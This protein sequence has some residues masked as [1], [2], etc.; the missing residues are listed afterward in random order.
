MHLCDQS[1]SCYHP[2]CAICEPLIL[3][4]EQEYS[5]APEQNYSAYGFVQDC[6]L[7][8]CVCTAL[9]ACIFKNGNAI[10]HVCCTTIIIAL[11]IFCYVLCSRHC[12]VPFNG[13]IK[14]HQV[15]R[16]SQVKPKN[17]LSPNSLVIGWFTI[18]GHT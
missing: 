11:V 15:T 10:V 6:S 1:L 5:C 17:A 4:S 13:Q 3:K 14:L 9:C 18:H 7:P 12:S 2:W 16:S 8:L